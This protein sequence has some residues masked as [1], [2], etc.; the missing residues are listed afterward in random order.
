MQLITTDDEQMGY[1]RD[2]EFDSH[3]TATPRPD[4]NSRGASR[5]AAT[6]IPR[7]PS[8]APPSKAHHADRKTR[9]SPA[10]AKATEAD[11]IKHKIP[12][13]YSLKNWDPAEEP[14]MLLGSV[15]DANSLGKWIYDW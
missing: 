4:T 8:C 2:G 6:S 13:G 10:I 12:A 11:A 1:T 9:P 3:Q 15:F 5:R 14:I 7:R